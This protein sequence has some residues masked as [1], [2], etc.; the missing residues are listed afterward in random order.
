SGTFNGTE[1]FALTQTKVGT[2]LRIRGLV[3]GDGMTLGYGGA[4]ANDTSIT[5]ATTLGTAIATGEITD[6]TITTADIDTTASNFV[7]DD[8][9]R[10]TSAVSDSQ[11][12]TKDYADGL[13][14]ATAYDDI[15]DPDASGSIAMGAHT[16]TYTTATDGWGG[17]TISNT[18]ADMTAQGWLLTLMYADDND[19]EGD[20]F[21]ILDN[22]SD[23]K[24]SITNA[25]VVNTYS[26]I[27]V[28]GS[29]LG[30]GSSG[31]SGF[32]LISAPTESSLE[33]NSP[34]GY[35]V[36]MYGD[37]DTTQFQIGGYSQYVTIREDTIIVGVWSGTSI[38]GA[39]ILDQTITTADIDTTA[40]NFVF[41]DAYRGTS[42]ISDSQYV[43]KAY[44]DGV[45]AGETNTLADSGTFNG[46]EGFSLTQT[47]VGTELRIRGL[48][49]GTGVTL[50]YGGAAAS[51]T[52]VT[53]STTLGTAIDSTEVTANSLSMT[54]D[55]HAFTSAELYGQISD[56]SGT[57]VAVFNTS[58]NFEGTVTLDDGV[59]NSPVLSI[60]DA[61]NKT[62]TIDKADAGP[63]RIANNEGAIHIQPS[64]DVNDYLSISTAT[65]I[66]TV[67]T[68]AGDNGDLVISAG[69]GDISFSDDNLSG[70]GIVDF[71]GA[72]SHE[73]PNGANPTTDA[74]GEE[75]FDTDDFAV[76]RYDGTRS[77]LVPLYVTKEMLFWAPDGITDTVPILECDSA[78]HQGGI[79]ILSVAVQT[80]VDGAYV[81]K[82]M[83]FDS[84]DPPAFHDWVDTLN[85][86]ASDQFA[87]SET[88]EDAD[89]SSLDVGQ[90][91]YALTPATDIDWIKIKIRYYIKEND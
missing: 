83:S 17:I 8:A 89:A 55:M 69:G 5:F 13:V 21:R 61:D 39:K 54:G 52:S 38:I 47:K 75:A 23:E 30:D 76:E 73:I 15:G 28:G 6:Q 27:H 48:V 2:E 44:A 65:G 49:E 34:E 67:T 43:T 36:K 87:T 56:E 22:T 9:Y 72:A 4:D 10:G 79:K 42:A 66:V 68:Q 82:L 29:I 35:P 45:A 32:N 86:G 64:G 7:F 57:G 80:S 40:S 50:G 88:F 60:I 85:V 11:Y 1:G 16:G 63:A 71:G 37:D 14:G 18:Q 70:T 26:S 19:F 62:L 59:G 46:T 25:G 84:A 24:F 33:I 91:L 58:P 20:F 53:V 51:D 81:L 90:K 12:V 3:E 77:V 78:I 31:L 41:D 74:A